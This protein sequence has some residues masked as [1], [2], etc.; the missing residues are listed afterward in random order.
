MGLETFADD[1]DFLWPSRNRQSS[2][3]CMSSRFRTNSDDCLTSNMQQ[4][5]CCPGS[6]FPLFE[7]NEMRS[8]EL[9]LSVDD[10][11]VVKDTSS[12]FDNAQDAMAECINENLNIITHLKPV[13]ISGSDELKSESFVEVKAILST[14]PC[15]SEEDYEPSSLKHR[16]KPNSP[17][18]MIDHRVKR[19][20]KTQE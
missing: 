2:E 10:F 9:H 14:N 5:I 4:Q 17:A 8:D 6:S 15:P 3:T 1:V 20:K 13:T 12:F 7:N 18:T 19:K 11:T 16:L